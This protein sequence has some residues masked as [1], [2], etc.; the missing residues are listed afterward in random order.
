MKIINLA[1]SFRNAA[2]RDLFNRIERY[3]H[4][5]V[6]DIGGG[7]FFRFIKKIKFTYWT[8]L[9]LCHQDK[10]INKILSYKKGDACDIPFADNS[11][12]TVLHSQVIEYAFNPE[13]MIEEA[14]RVTRPG[15]I[16]ILLSP[17]STPMHDIPNH[18]VNVTYFWLRKALTKNN[19]KI[20]EEKQLGG[21]W[22]S[23]AF[24]HIYFFLYMFKTQ[25][26]SDPK[27][28][29]HPLFYFIAPIMSIYAVI[30]I[31]ICL[32]FSLFDL[33]EDANNNLF[34]ARKCHHDSL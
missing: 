27:L 5:K 33:S 19:M 24:R 4:G 15:G 12:D 1:Y 30:N 14:C 11:F 25:Y 21:V 13:K 17:Q 26:W 8:S 22:R 31:P 7:D 2:N 6:L 23:I 3:T 10:K 32:L 9:D 28:K 18:M 29:R 16:L 34:V 20:L